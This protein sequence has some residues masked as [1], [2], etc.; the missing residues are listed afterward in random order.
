MVYNISIR[1]VYQ[2]ALKPT[3]I[4]TQFFLKIFCTYSI[5]YL[6]SKNQVKTLSLMISDIQINK[7]QIWY[8][9]IPLTT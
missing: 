6:L 9:K 5:S 8:G 2:K 3:N 7:N 1:F 4:L